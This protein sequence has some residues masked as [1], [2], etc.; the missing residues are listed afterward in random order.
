ML[1]FCGSRKLCDYGNKGIAERRVSASLLWCLLSGKGPRYTEEVC[2]GRLTEK[3]NKPKHV[4]VTDKN[5]IHTFD[6]GYDN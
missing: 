3:L 5:T 2:S 6:C 4:V 1:I